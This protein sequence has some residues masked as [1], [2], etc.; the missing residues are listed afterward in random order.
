[1]MDLAPLLEEAE[2]ASPANR[3]ELRDRI[4]AHGSRAIEGVKPWLA[5]PVLAAFA[6]RVIERAGTNG[7]AEHASQ[8]LRS[9]RT[10]VSKAVKG[11]IDW[12][13]HQLRARAQSASRTSHADRPRTRGIQR[14]LRRQEPHLSMLGRPRARGSAPTRPR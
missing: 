14:P 13:L 5:D 3:I 1:M 12:A 7:E 2:A 9:A 6:I 8:V 10:K 4:A 11:D